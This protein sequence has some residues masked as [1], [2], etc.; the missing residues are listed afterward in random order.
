MLQLKNISKTYRVGD[1]ETQA[2][3]KINVSF[4]E[5]EFVAI[6]GTSGSGKTTCL[7]IIGGLDRYDEGD[8]I[9]NGKHTKDF[10]EKDWD[11]YRNNSIGF[12]FQSYHL[13]PH[14]SIVAN[15]E[16]GMTLSG[17]AAKQ[18]H[19]RA[20]EVLTKVGLKDHLHKKPNQLSGGQ[21]QRVAIARALANNPD[22]L[23]CDEPTGALDSTTST[24]IMD[25]IQEVAKERL[26]I[27]VT[28]N[29]ELAHQYAS[30]IIQF[31]DGE[32]ISDS[33]PYTIEKSN[34]S[35]SLTKTYMRFFTALKLSFHNIMSKKGRTL[36]TSFASSIGIIGIALILSLSNGFQIQIDQFQKETLAEFPLTISQTAMN[37]DREAL[38]NHQ[39]EKQQE[40]AVSPTQEVTLYDSSASSFRHKNI[41]TD[42]YIDYIQNIDP[43]I[44]QSIAYTRLLNINV[45]RKTEQG[46]LP[47]SFASSTKSSKQGLTS[48]PKQLQEG[49]MSYL[50]KHYDL[51]EG[52]FPSEITDLMLV[53]DEKNRLDYTV[54][55]SLGFDVSDGN[56]LAYK[57][58]V[59]TQ[60]VWVPNDLYYHKTSLG[61][62]MPKGNYEQMYHSAETK[63]LKIKGIIRQKEGEKIPTLA[64]GIV[65]S[66]DLAQSIINNHMSSEIVKAQQNADYNVLN[67]EK[68]D[69]K[70]KEMLL[71]Y[72]G[73]SHIPQA[74]MLYPQ[75]FEAKDAVLRYLDA[76]NEGKQESDKIYYTDLANNISEMSGGIMSGITLVLI[77]FS[78]ISLLVS[79]LMISIITY[80][81]VLERTKEIGILRALGARRKDIA[82]V[83]DAETCILGL[84]SGTLGIII[85]W[86]LTYPINSV[87]YQMTELENVAQLH[88]S[89]AI[90]LIVI[91]TLL[92]MLGGHIPAKIASKKD[93]VEAL[94]SS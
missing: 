55:K 36:L 58:I 84:F 39:Q 26:V 90:I 51:L 41:L 7:N 37:I 35:F 21:M 6:L 64:S 32:I 44:C 89:H 93:T 23:L 20:I 56:T 48:Y 75:N 43:A 73:G 42:A 19:E 57:D 40:K 8:L 22:I 60:F 24:Q 49:Q 54:M 72:L 27:M 53:V 62:Y 28:H 77:A 45:L 85:A 94:R 1:I 82:R 17:V 67:L 29:P 18:K 66:D 47:V 38:L 79:L 52:E 61:M 91:S 30:R 59:G 78:S 63:T 14:I 83:F 2:L 4:R 46:V 88:I 16:M 11:A 92:T 13:I 31:K 65:Y 25:L 76:Y 70:D 9:I 69:E 34:S 87:I 86:I 50:E 71:S 74:M 5:K 3:K 33:K 80:T 68:I 10:Q 81:S 12:V 15:V